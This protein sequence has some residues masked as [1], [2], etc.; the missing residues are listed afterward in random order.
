MAD[1]VANPERGEVEVVLLR[2]GKE[3]RFVLR[4]TFGAVAEIEAGTGKG[5]LM[6][7]SEL[8]AD[9][10]RGLSLSALMAI[11]RAGLRA[12]G[13]K[14]NEA[15]LQAMVFE[16]GIQSLAAPCAAFLA[17]A[18]RGGKPALDDEA[19]EAEAGEE[20]ATEAATAADTPSVA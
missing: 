10:M 14:F 7:A 5:I 11:V 6:L 18:I 9:P 3:K 4:P 15:A 8:M 13:E 12:S 17:S 2:D 19:G 20:R 16:T 1:K